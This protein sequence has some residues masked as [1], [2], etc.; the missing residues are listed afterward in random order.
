[1]ERYWSPALVT[2]A[3]SAAITSVH[4]CY[5]SARIIIGADCLL[6]PLLLR[7][8]ALLLL[9]LP[10][11]QQLLLLRPSF[12]TRPSYI[13]YPRKAQANALSSTLISELHAALAHASADTQ[14]TR[15]IV[16]S[17]G[18]EKVFCAGHDLKDM[19]TA[20]EYDLQVSSFPLPRV[21]YHWVPLGI[22]IGHNIQYEYTNIASSI[23]LLHPSPPH[24][25][26]HPDSPTEG[27]LC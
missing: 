17:S 1:M 8:L 6:L 21:V 10:L 9:P 24:S 22:S 26:R 15:V 5:R 16:L 2:T 12:L 4:P 23:M 13:T 14:A 7:P 25:H 11:L 27:P 18:L 19:S 3:A 20:D